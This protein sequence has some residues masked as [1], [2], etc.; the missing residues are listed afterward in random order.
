MSNLKTAVDVV[1]FDGYVTVCQEKPSGMIT[2]RGKFDSKPFDNVLKKATGIE[3]PHIRQFTQGDNGTV[4]WMSPDEL[5]LLCS[6]KNKTPLMISLQK[7]LGTRHAMVVDIS[8]AC[9]TFKLKGAK[10]REV[11]AKLAPVDLS[12][13][14]FAPGEVRRTRFGQIAATF[15]LISQE[16][17]KIICF[18]SVGD[19]MLQQLKAAARSGSELGIWNQQKLPVGL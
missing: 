2:L 14:S 15:W 19:Y 6:W 3:L 17:A 11:I 4:A 12:P 18:R 13:G 7:A 10:V 9:T 1:P 8:D 16:E 5:L